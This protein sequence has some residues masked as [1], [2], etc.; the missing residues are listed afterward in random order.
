MNETEKEFMYILSD[1]SQSITWMVKEILR[2]ETEISIEHLET[3]KD[4]RGT[5]GSLHTNI[6]VEIPF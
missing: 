4:V 6:S 1:L 5:L 3:L 2:E